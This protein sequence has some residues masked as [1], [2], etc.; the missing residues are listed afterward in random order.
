MW[1]GVNKGQTRVNILSWEINMP[2][3]KADEINERAAKEEFTKSGREGKLA[4]A[5]S[6][7]L[8]SASESRVDGQRQSTKRSQQVFQTERTT[9]VVQSAPIQKKHCPSR[10]EPSDWRKQEVAA[11]QIRIRF[12]VGALQGLIHTVSATSIKLQQNGRE[13][14]KSQP[15]CFANHIAKS[16]GCHP[17][18]TSKLV[19]SVFRTTMWFDCLGRGMG[20]GKR[21]KGGMARCIRERFVA[22]R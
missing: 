14:F 11:C 5:L 19:S 3:R 18:W 20:G 2:Q 7:S 10:A 12:S 16:S 4:A 22:E 21:I 9:F 17:E 1:Y 6:L 8:L 15:F 13:V